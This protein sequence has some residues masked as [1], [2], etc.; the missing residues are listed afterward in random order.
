MKNR[1]DLFKYTDQKDIYRPAIAGIFH[2]IDPENGKGVAVATD[3][4]VMIVSEAAYNPEL[5]GK[6]E[7]KKGE[8]LT[9]GQQAEI[10]DWRDKKKTQTWTVKYPKWEDVLPKNFSRD[11]MAV[12]T[13]DFF[14]VLRCARNFEKNAPQTYEDGSRITKS[15]RMVRVRVTVAGHDGE[16]HNIYFRPDKLALFLDAIGEDGKIYVFKGVYGYGSR[17]IYGE[18]QD[19]C[20]RSL[21]MPVRGP[22]T[23]VQNALDEKGIAA[24]TDDNLYT[25]L[26][27]VANLPDRSEEAKRLYAT[28]EKKERVPQVKVIRPR[29][30]YS[31]MGQ[32][33]AVVKQF[34]SAELRKVEGL[35]TMY[36]L[37]AEIAKNFRDRDEI[38]KFENG[39]FVYLGTLPENMGA[40]S[41]AVVERADKLTIAGLIEA[42]KWDVG[43]VLATYFERTGQQ[44]PVKENAA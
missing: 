21:L 18:S 26:V 7:L 37:R 33:K 35:E 8:P 42:N 14:G 10:P 36:T 39:Y 2:T 13:A 43:P 6:I 27:W 24:E 4:I 16:D 25:G 1:I 31:M 28:P 19:G 15:H 38:Y 9:I 32:S 17:A 3:M 40:D 11:W 30:G 29:R 5:Q 22:E 34:P 44:A 23:H 20:T 12:P 41:R